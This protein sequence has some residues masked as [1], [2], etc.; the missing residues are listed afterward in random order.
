MTTE[1]VF[2]LGAALA[3]A[4][5]TAMI[6]SPSI[7]AAYAKDYKEA[8]YGPRDGEG[9]SVNSCFIHEEGPRSCESFKEN[10]GMNLNK[11]SK[12]QCEDH[13]EVEKCKKIK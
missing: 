10:R 13:F 12:T 3:L 6:I 11:A 7:T 2:A 4:A 5:A 9:T 8:V 1:V